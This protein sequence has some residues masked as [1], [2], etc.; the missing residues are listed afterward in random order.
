MSLIF[1]HYWPLLL[2]GLIPVLLWVRRSSAVDLSPRHLSLSLL[3]R[4]ALIVLLALALMQPTVLRSSAR[5][6]TVYL[7]DISQ[8]VSPTAVQEALEWIRKTDAAGGASSSRFLAFGANSLAF[9]TPE[10]LAK[11][12]V[13]TKPQPGAIDQSKTALASALDHAARSFPPDHVKHL[14]VLSDGNANSGNLAAALEH[15]RLENIHV[16]TRSLNARSTKD[17]WIEAMLAP[18]SVTAE[19]QF[20]VEVHVY[21]QIATPATIELRNGD[22]LLEKRNVRLTEGL[23]RVA[24]AT[25]VKD[26]STTVVL[27][28][29]VTVNGDPLPVN[30]TF[31][32]SATVLGKPHI[33]YVEG[34][35]PSARYL[36][37]ALTVEGFQV[38]VI[39]ADKMPAT[40]DKLDAY[41]AVVISDVDRK[42]FTEQQ[43][44]AVATYVRD[45]GGGFLMAG[46]ENTY[47]KEGY[48]GSTLEEVLPVTFETDKE[49]QSISMV[50]VLDRSGSMAGSKMDL[51]KEATKAPLNLLKEDDHFGVLTFDYNFQWALKIAEA[52]NKE[53][54]RETISKI[55]ATGNT[56]I[57]PALREAYE[58]LKEAPGETKHIILLSDGQTP[59]EDFKG[60][61]Q[62]MLKDKITVSTVAVTAASDR[63]LM[64]NIAEWGGGRAYYVENPQSVPQIFQDETELAAGKSIQEENFKPTV[65][66]TVEAFKGIDFKTAPELLGYVAT[67]A[68]P[69]AELILETPGKRPLLA[70]WQYALGKSAMFT[71]DV[72]DRWAADWLK[73]P[74]YSKFWA[75]LLRETMR[76]QDNDE[77]DLQVERD[78][79]EAVIAINAVE[80]DGRFRNLLHPKLRIVDPAQG[81]S[82]IEV[83]QVGP[84]SYET[85]FPLAQDGAY[86]FRTVSDAPGGA[87]RTLEYSY[88][89]EY[90]FYPP[91][92]Q[93]LR[94]ISNET[95]G[96]YQPAGPEI[97]DA[98]GETVSVHTRL[99]PLLAALALVLYIS[100]VFL[101]RLRLFEE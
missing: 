14:V 1:E 80:K 75:Q 90:H 56:N 64:Q 70:R 69:T 40:A 16:F 11:V 32:K 37:N 63:V 61:A 41:D 46:G 42:D 93:T 38:E 51:A 82:T 27:S 77:F 19:E 22:S 88:P 98:K 17:T 30:N 45:L 101:R 78:G 4:S 50:V 74:S 3:I 15:L 8:S 95:G 85:R 57:Y 31:R 2:L 21:S 66:K 60:L 68:K 58:Q 94:S 23:N 97:F 79:D 20:P 53:S 72:K 44:Q 55:V 62:E 9:D 49:R 71:S 84:G 76:R 83:P 54:M 24:F 6:A 7:L 5:V 28:A 65:K 35:A 52:K 39:S 36:K 100:D 67:K 86:V 91:D 43:M 34:Y 87:S 73:W 33:L 92:F 26:E 59:A 25:N 29:S 47:G 81:A 13:S 48:T 18:S 99:W 96:V 10:E 89:D 12:P